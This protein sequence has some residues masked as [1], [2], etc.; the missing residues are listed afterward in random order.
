MPSQIV[1]HLAATGGVTDMH[2]ILE[3]EM[4]GKRREVV[5]IMIHVVTVTRLR[6][7]A[8]AA[9]VMGYDA[10]AVMQEEQHLGVPVIC[11]QRPAVTE[12]DGLTLAPILVE[13]LNAV[14]GCDGG[15]DTRVSGPV[16]FQPPA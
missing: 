11:R 16:C 7:P 13:D 5:G 9:A 8:V 2:G 3:V 15:H 12:H 6:G 10:I 4:R 1:R 14:L